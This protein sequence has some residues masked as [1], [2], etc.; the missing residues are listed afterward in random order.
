MKLV[1]PKVSPKILK[2]LASFGYAIKESETPSTENLPDFPCDNLKLLAKSVELNPMISTSDSINCLY[3]YQLFL[4]KENHKN[5]QFLFNSLEIPLS[6]H[7]KQSKVLSV[8]RD[9][10]KILGKTSIES[11]PSKDFF[12]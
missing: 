1:A 11:I 3:P 12:N 10:D 4:P 8:E 9:G 7:S 6:D 5:L 2:K